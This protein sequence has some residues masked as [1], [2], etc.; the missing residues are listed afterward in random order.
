MTVAF[1]TPL[2]MGFSRQE[3]WG[4]FPRP[5]PGDLRDPGTEPASLVSP[6]LAVGFST[7]TPPGNQDYA[8]L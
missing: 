7:C 8:V 2:S 5:V 3:H 4:R 6:A 1:Q